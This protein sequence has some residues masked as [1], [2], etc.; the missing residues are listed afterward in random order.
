[1]MSLAPEAPGPNKAL[2]SQTWTVSRGLRGMDLPV[3]RVRKLAPH[4]HALRIAE[5]DV[6]G[7]L[8][9]DS[10]LLDAPAIAI[11]G[12]RAAARDA[13]EF[14]TELGR[15]VAA[16]GHS[17]ISGGA[18]GV[19]GA[20]HEGA[21]SIDG[22]T[23]AVL[24]TGVD[25]VYPERH[26]A[27]FGRMCVRGGLVSPFVRGTGP[28]RGNFPAR[29][30]LIAALA[31]AVVVVEAGLRS[32]SLLTA[33]AALR[34]GVPLY[35][36]PGSAGC[37]G[38]IVRGLAIAAPSVTWLAERFFGVRAAVE[39]A[40]ELGDDQRRLLASCATATDA[41]SLS[42]ALSMPLDEVLGLLLELELSRRVIRFQDGRYLALAGSADLKG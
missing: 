14:A 42:D 7:A 21:L 27:L 18:L 40:D 5:V 41:G 10:G 9:I 20:A 16:Q 13:I 8:S 23:I 24:G 6:A 35:C 4:A 37:N 3:A 17:V 31:D 29:N 39:G 26:G 22:R 34:L 2:A 30:P 12:A 38:L 32:G 1:M 15:L 36:R 19:D 33:H 25:L 28:R 11:V